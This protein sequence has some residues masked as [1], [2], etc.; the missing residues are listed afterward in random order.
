M[1][2]GVIVGCSGGKMWKIGKEETEK[3]RW[4]RRMRE[5]KECRRLCE[6]SIE[7][8]INKR[9]IKKEDLNNGNKRSMGFCKRWKIQGDL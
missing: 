6:K 4:G 9:K 2:V 7:E 1:S 5:R 8:K 3:E